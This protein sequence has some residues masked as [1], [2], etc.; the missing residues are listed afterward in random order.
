MTI[1]KGEQKGLI[2]GIAFTALII[3]GGLWAFGIVDFTPEE[4]LTYYPGEPAPPAPG[5]PGAVTPAE[6]VCLLSSKS[7]VTVRQVDRYNPSTAIV[8]INMHRQPGSSW[9]DV[10]GA[11]NIEKTGYTLLEFVSGID[12]DDETSNE[13]GPYYPTLKMPCTYAE[14][15]IV[16]V[17]NDAEATDLTATTFDEHGTAGATQAVS[18]KDEVI[19]EF[20]FRGPA[21]EDYGNAYC[22][23]NPSVIDDTMTNLVVFR[24]NTTNIDKVELR[25]LRNTNTGATYPVTVAGMP[26]GVQ[27]TLLTDNSSLTGFKAYLFPVLQDGETIRGSYLLDVDDT[28]EC[29]SDHLNIDLFDSTWYLDNDDGLIKW[30]VE[31][32]NNV[33]IGNTSYDEL[34]PLFS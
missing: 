16:M 17:A 3:V 15:F 22:G 1:K 5:V 2:M 32:E 33:N 10:A 23:G 18:A 14:D 27:N 25:S 26:T 4:P 24:Y 6:D 8:G 28:V 13:Y 12:S 19:M 11:A 31:D 21:D 9:T 30:G 7:I 20:S 34:M 29:S